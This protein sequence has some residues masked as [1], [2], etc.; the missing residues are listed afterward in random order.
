MAMNSKTLLR[1]GCVLTFG[2]KT[3]NFMEAD[4]L[5][6]QGRIA[7]VGPGLRAR[8]AEWRC[9]HHR[10]AGFVEPSHAWNRC[11][12]LAR[13]APSGWTLNLT[14]A[15]S[16]SLRP[17][18]SLDVYSATLIGHGCDRGREHHGGRLVDVQL[19]DRSVD[20]AFKPM[21]MPAAAGIRPLRSGMA[22]CQSVVQPFFAWRRVHRPCQVDYHHRIRVHRAR[23][24]NLDQLFG[25][26]SW[27]GPGARIHAHAGADKAERRVV[28]QLAERGMLGEDVTLVHCANLDDPDLDAIES[29]GASIALAPSSEM[30]GGAGSLPIQKLI[31][32][33]IRPGLAVA[34]ERVAPGDMFAQMRAAISLQHATLFD[35]KLAGKAGVPH[36]MSTRDII[37]YA[38]IDGARVAGLG[39]VP[40]R[41]NRGGMPTRRP[42]GRPSQHLPDQRPDRSCGLGDGHVQCRLGLCR[43][44]AL[45]RNGILE[46]DVKAGPQPGGDRPT[47]CGPC[48]RSPDREPGRMTQNRPPSSALTSFV[49][50][51][52]ICRSTWP[53]SCSSAWPPLG[54]DALGG[55][56]LGAIAPFGALLGVTALGQML[57]I[58]NGGIDLSVP[59]TLTLAAV[60]MVGVGHQANDRI[61]LALVTALGAAALIGLV[62]GIL[63]GGLKLNALIVTLAVGQ[64][65]IGVVNR[66][67]R[68]F[69]QS[70]VRPVVWLDLTPP[71]SDPDLLIV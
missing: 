17:H 32:R 15:S 24:A 7:E 40:D 5:I 71:R 21:S 64:V 53:C 48:R 49:L 14:M 66:Y 56:A 43:R 3:P 27:R 4:V 12:E 42:A 55:V 70:P 19:D 33:G 30:G 18:P 13:V 37:R 58:M 60:I 36:L 8:D 22:G 68:S 51:P 10:H 6:D 2:A 47:S 62:N 31:D 44:T 29:K 26:G 54:P 20:A 45:M 39:A 9:G 41:W 46:A 67:G 11:S 23:P 65:A 38:T 34:D 69:L 25:A 59:G 57:V 61:G 16:A 28:S 63:I 50:R 52:G 35:L 1:G